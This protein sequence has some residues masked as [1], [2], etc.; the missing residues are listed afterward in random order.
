MTAESVTV[1]GAKPRAGKCSS[2]ARAIVQRLPFSQ[3][4][5]AAERVIAS[6]PTLPSW[7]FRRSSR[8]GGPAL[9]TDEAPSSAR[10][11][12]QCAAY[13]GSNEFNRT[14]SDLTNLC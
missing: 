4:E 11:A 13:F 1:V 12:V 6:T 7:K 3:A 5:I 9:K 8:M 2:S 14:I 10:A